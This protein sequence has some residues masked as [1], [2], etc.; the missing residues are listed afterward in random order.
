MVYYQPVINATTKELVGAEALL[1]WSSENI[2]IIPPSEFIP[3]A[4]NLGLIIELGDFVIRQACKECRKWISVGLQSFKMNINLSVGQLNDKDIV[5]RIKNIII[6]ENVPFSNICFEITE[7]MAIIDTER[8]TRIL[9]CFSKLGI[10]IALDDF[11]TGYSSLNNIKNMPLSVV[12]I[13]KSFIDDFLVN[14]HTEIFVKTIT[15]LAHALNIKV[16]AEGVEQK[17]QYER[18]VELET[19]IIQGY[20]FGRPIPAHEFE[21]QFYFGKELQH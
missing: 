15:N 7:S 3:L 4:E 14:C 2:G 19:D 21:K 9:N 20:Y 5:T 13:D 10:E 11:G 16:C 12:K 17:E 1:R 6:E 18:L 8:T